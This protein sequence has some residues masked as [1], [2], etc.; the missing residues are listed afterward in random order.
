MLI[1]GLVKQPPS[2]STVDATRAAYFSLAGNRRIH[3]VVPGAPGTAGS[4]AGLVVV[5][6]LAKWPLPLQ[7]AAVTGLFLLG[8]AIS[9]SAERW[10]DTKDPGA[11][12]IDEIVGMILALLAVPHQIGYVVAAFFLFRLLDILKPLG[13]SG[14][15]AR[16]LGS[17]VR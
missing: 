14:A 8:V 10:L 15:L 12:V 17:D 3:W 4:V 2:S 5:W 16:W 7:A 13:G 1:G 6:I 11:I 9:G